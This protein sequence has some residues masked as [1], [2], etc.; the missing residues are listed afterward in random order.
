MLALSHRLQGDS[1]DDCRV[2]AARK[3][4]SLVTSTRT[5]CLCFQAA[6]VLFR[7]NLFA[8]LTLRQSS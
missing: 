7:L 1:E 4:V 8:L 3:P 5:I 2:F 6:D